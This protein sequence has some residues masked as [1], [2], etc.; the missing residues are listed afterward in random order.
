M[1]YIIGLHCVIGALR[2]TL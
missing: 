1:V 2:C